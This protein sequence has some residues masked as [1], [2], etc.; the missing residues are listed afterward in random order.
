[1]DEG[2]QKI[3]RMPLMSRWPLN[4][5]RKRIKNHLSCAFLLTWNSR[6]RGVS[7]R[8]MAWTRHGF[9]L[10]ICAILNL[11]YGFYSVVRGEAVLTAIAISTYLIVIYAVAAI[12]EEPGKTETRE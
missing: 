5:D 2:D 4:S 6:L 7:V 9:A 3:R 10:Y 1:M 11:L 8:T 12:E